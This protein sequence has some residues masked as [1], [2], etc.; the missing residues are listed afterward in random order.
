MT[1]ASPVSLS[2]SCS[3][4]PIKAAPLHQQIDLPCTQYPTLTGSVLFQYHC[5]A[6]AVLSRHTPGDP[7]VSTDA[8]L[9]TRDQLLHI[10]PR[11]SLLPLWL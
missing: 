8:D 6:C 10:K 9:G 5:T 4:L 11:G 3:A 2:G 7:D 1:P